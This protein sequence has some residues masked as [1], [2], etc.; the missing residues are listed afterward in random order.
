MIIELLVIHDRNVCQILLKGYE[1]FGANVHYACHTR[2]ASLQ[3]SENNNRSRLLLTKVPF[4]VLD[5]STIL[6][7]V[8]GQKYPDRDLISPLECVSVR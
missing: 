5:S 6:E 8:Y 7:L 2:F 1:R 3:F 4:T